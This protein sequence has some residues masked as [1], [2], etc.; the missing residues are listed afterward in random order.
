MD[1]VKELVKVVD[2][3]YASVV[4]DG[5]FAGDCDTFIDSGSFILNAL[6]SGDIY[7]GL[8]ANKVTALAG[9]TATGK[10]FVALGIVKSFLE[11]NEKAISVIFETES[12][13]T[14]QMIV[15]RGVDTTRL[16][17]IPVTT[18]QEFR[19]QALKI[20]EKYKETSE[21]ERPPMLFVLDSLGNLS[22]TKEITDSNE[23]K[24][25]QDM[26]RS[27][28]IKGVFRVLTL[29]LSKVKV[30][31]VV[32]NHTYKEVGSMFPQDIMGGG[33]GIAY[34]ASTIVFLSKKK[35]KDGDEVVGNIIHCK[36]FKN[37]LAKENKK[38]DVLLS[39]DKGLNRYYGLVDIAIES[40]IF[41]KVSTRIELPDGTKVFEKQLNSHP[42]KYY[43][44]EILDQINICVKRT[45]RYGQPECKIE[46]IV[47]KE[48]D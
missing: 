45:F 37:R 7:G 10:T 28:L 42:E 18:V 23:G 44:K 16:V 39:Y 12:A 9:P 11:S 31:L 29:A 4:S 24:E 17:I 48:I 46:N 30:P 40:G 19:T 27:R 8:A 15:E 22:T 1:F 38:V 34:A 5:V 25:T 20:L 32:T 33:S 21:E 14:K 6:L 26:T 43:T 2:N 13:L 35:E 47:E 41:K 36:N 3:E